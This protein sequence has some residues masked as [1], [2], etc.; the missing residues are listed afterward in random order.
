MLGTVQGCQLEAGVLNFNFLEVEITSHQSV[1]HP[2]ESTTV[3]FRATPLGD[4][5]PVSVDIGQTAGGA[6]AANLDPAVIVADV[7]MAPNAETGFRDLVIASSRPND[8]V[9]LPSAVLVR[10]YAGEF[11]PV[12]PARIVDSRSGVGGRTGPLASRAALSFQVTGTGG[13]PASGVDAVVMNVTVV[14]PTADSYL[15]VWPSDADQPNASNLNFVAGQTVPNLVTTK[16]SSSGLVGVFAG[17]GQFQVIFDVVGWYS[18]PTTTEAGAAFVAVAPTRLLDTRSDAPRTPIGPKG[19]IRLRVA[20]PDSGVTA[21]VLNVTATDPT[22]ASFLSVVPS[23]VAP[24]TSNLNFVA[25]Q[26]VPNLVVVPVGIDGA[27]DI[28]NG[29]GQVHVIVDL[30]GFFDDGSL[31]IDDGQLRAVTPVRVLD[32]RSG[33]GVKA[34]KV[35]PDQSVIIDL[36]ARVPAGT[37]A[38][39]LNV[40]VADPGST[41]YVSLW[42]SD[43]PKPATSN[44]NFTAGLTVPN[45]VIVP[46]SADGSVKIAAAESG[47]HLIADLLGSFGTP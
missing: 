11:H 3:A 1:V 42:P 15:T 44:L 46:I 32:T 39:V 19:P 45:L 5:R 34:G 12:E 41:G 30:F 23:N 20:E 16:V 35:Q 38:V 40:T 17:A 25:D 9:V 22:A 28:Y 36:A 10:E 33:I 21:V 24:T 6:L 37:S 26:T 47:T 43:G 8:F 31:P 27:I 13:V 18:S 2:G 4:F 29:V 7:T 14:G